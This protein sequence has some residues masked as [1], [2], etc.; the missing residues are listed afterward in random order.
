MLISEHD[1]ELRK[2][3]DPGV[4]NDD[5]FIT[6]NDSVIES[7]AFDDRHMKS[8]PGSRH[9]SGRE[10][11]NYPK[12]ANMISSKQNLTAKQPNKQF[13][14]IMLTEQIPGTPMTQKSFMSQQNA[15]AQVNP[16]FGASFGDIS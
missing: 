9:F 7:S 12:P 3:L 15:G 6:R 13:N 5:D 14:N 4:F 11:F 2:N 10:K 1:D 8:T 16:A